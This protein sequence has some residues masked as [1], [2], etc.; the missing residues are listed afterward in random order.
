MMSLPSH[1]GDGTTM[2]TLA[3]VCCRVMLVMALPSL[4]SDGIAEVML[5]MT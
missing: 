4:A 3:V 2:S 5:P 1:A